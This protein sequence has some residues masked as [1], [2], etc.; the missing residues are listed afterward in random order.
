MN[1][2]FDELGYEIFENVLDGN[3]FSKLSIL[4]NFY[5]QR[6]LLR[7]NNTGNVGVNLFRTENL[8]FDFPLPEIINNEIIYDAVKRFLGSNFLLQELYFY[9]ALP[10]NS[11]QELHK[12]G[13]TIFP[14]ISYNLPPHI[15]AVQI[16][17]TDFNAKSGGTRIVPKSHHSFEEPTRI[18]DEDISSIESYTPIVT[19]QSCII[20]D[21]RAWHGAGVNTS[22]E[23][24]AMCTL[25][26]TKPF[27]GQPFAISKDLFFCIDKKKRHIVTYA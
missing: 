15:I 23:I 26:F 11:I 21:A 3:T 17:L 12:D 1:N 6:T 16:P 18:E 5:I 2:T 14:E 19:K 9:F 7:Q 27:I 24:R 10:N 25:A 22:S 13:V 20:R 4:S 8:L